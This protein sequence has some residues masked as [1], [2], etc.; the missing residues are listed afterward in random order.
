MAV[1]GQRDIKNVALTPSVRPLE[2]TKLGVIFIGDRSPWNAIE[3]SPS[4]VLKLLAKERLIYS[5]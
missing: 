3:V 1:E 2:D 4:I 5:R